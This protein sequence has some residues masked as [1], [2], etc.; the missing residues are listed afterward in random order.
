MAHHEPVRVKKKQKKK[1]EEAAKELSTSSCPCL[2]RVRQVPTT[3]A[4][5]GAAEAPL[6]MRGDPQLQIPALQTQ[7][8]L[9]IRQEALWCQVLGPVFAKATSPDSS[10]GPDHADSS[11][12][13]AQV[14]VLNAERCYSPK[15]ESSRTGQNQWRWWTGRDGKL[16][17]EITPLNTS[18]P[19]STLPSLGTLFLFCSISSPV[20]ELGALPSRVP[21]LPPQLLALPCSH[22]ASNS[23]PTMA[24]APR[25]MCVQD[26]LCQ[27]KS[28]NLPPLQEVERRR[29]RTAQEEPRSALL[30]TGRPSREWLWPQRCPAAHVA[31]SLCPCQLQKLSSEGVLEESL[32]ERSGAESWHAV[33][34]PAASFK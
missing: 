15:A 12:S 23:C 20:W 14:P 10:V 30:T 5:R 28:L 9:E 26:T 3:S 29:A 2:Q 34:G 11:S 13:P 17:I 33:A 32:P 21:D 25:A 1:R 16:C 4:A 24:C 18:G 19:G 27:F 7:T 31:A 22:A 8:T 6:T